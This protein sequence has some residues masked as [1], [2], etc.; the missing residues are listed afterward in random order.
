MSKL[1]P[2]LIPFSQSDRITKPW[3]KRAVWYASP[4][5]VH[6]CMIKIQNE[7]KKN[8]QSPFTCIVPGLF[9]NYRARKMDSKVYPIQTMLINS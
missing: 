2:L 4:Y 3:G 8:G 7:Q 5:T 1:M 6:N 9:N